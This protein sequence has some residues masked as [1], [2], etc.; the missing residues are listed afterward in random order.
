[1]A[2]VHNKLFVVEITRTETY[3]HTVRV[4]AKDEAEARRKVMNFD[5]DDGFVNEWNELEPSVD[6]E[7]EA[8]E[9]IDTNFDDQELKDLPEVR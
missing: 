9:A 2:R 8:T 1:M 5:D 4:E 3:T 6:T 7:Y